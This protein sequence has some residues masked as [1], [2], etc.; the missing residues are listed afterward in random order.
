MKKFEYTKIRTEIAINDLR[1]LG[2]EGW[3]LV[4][5]IT[6]D[7]KSRLLFPEWQPREK[8]YLIFKR[9]GPW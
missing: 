4:C 5:E 6:L 1:S 8:S 9:E 3:E 7:K 2:E